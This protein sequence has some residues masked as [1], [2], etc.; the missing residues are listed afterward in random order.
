[1]NKRT[2]RMKKWALTPVYDGTKLRARQAVAGPAIVEE[3][4][5]TI[6]VPPKWT[7]KLDARGNYVATN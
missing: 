2:D 4:F 6:V 3:P 5:T 7:V 1:M